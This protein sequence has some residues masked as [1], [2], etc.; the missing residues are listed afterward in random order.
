MRF[1]AQNMTYEY[2]WRRCAS[3]CVVHIVDIMVTLSA[4][5]LTRIQGPIN[6]SMGTISS[7]VTDTSSLPLVGEF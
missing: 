3:G 1:S 6:S 4:V 5:I 7:K 2:K